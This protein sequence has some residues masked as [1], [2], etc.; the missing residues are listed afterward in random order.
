MVLSDFLSRQ[1]HNDS[2][3]HKI[4]PIS[5][6]MDQVLHENYYDIEN[7]ENHL[8]QTRCQMKS[9]GVKL[10]EVCGMRRNLDPKILPDKQHANSTKGSIEKPHIGQERAGLR[11]KGSAPINQTITPPSVFLSGTEN[12]WRDISRNKENK[13]CKFQWIQHLL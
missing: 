12:S 5:F 7:T 2:N 13:L 11:R 8:V 10:P 9:N 1:K 3:P 4:I 6:N